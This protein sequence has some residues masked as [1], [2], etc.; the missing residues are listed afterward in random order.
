MC[1]QVPGCYNR[2]SEHFIGTEGST[3]GDGSRME[4]KKNINPPQFPEY[5]GPYCQEHIDLLNSIIKNEPINEARNVAE[6]TMVAIMS[7]ISAYTGQMIR[8]SD[9]TENEQSPWYS[10]TL[11]PTAEDFEKGDVQAPPDDVVP[12]PGRPIGERKIIM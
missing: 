7:R 9:V 1:R 2:V 8:W 10:F 11:K 5:E 4:S 12:K 6:S 3:L